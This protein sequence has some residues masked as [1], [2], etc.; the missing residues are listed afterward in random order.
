MGTWLTALLFFGLL[1]LAFV[2]IILRNG[3]SKLFRNITTSSIIH[4]NDDE[5]KFSYWLIIPLFIN[6]MISIPALIILLIEQYNFYQF[7]M[8]SHFSLFIILAIGIL[9]FFMIKNLLISFSGF[10]FKSIEDSS[11]Y[12]R[13]NLSFLLIN[14][15]I[16]LPFIFLA[17]F[18]NTKI[19]LIIA[20]AFILIFNIFKFFRLFISGFS[21]VGYNLYY[22]FIYL[23]TFEF[24]PVLVIMKTI[25]IQIK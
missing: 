6:A 18:S 23:C 19:F 11:Q 16:T 8:Q 20:L 9:G 7:D 25:L 15:I 4:F 13:T 1:L 5:N 21:K 10:A 3:Y 14:G 24:L 12:V 17:Y 22:K 2:R